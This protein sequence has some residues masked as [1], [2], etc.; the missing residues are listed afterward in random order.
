MT[1]NFFNGSRDRI[2]KCREHTLTW[3]GIDQMIS[4]LATYVR[5]DYFERILCISRG[6]LALGGLLGYAL[7]IRHI[8]VFCAVSYDER[9]QKEIQ[10]LD[11]PN[12]YQWDR[13]TTLIVDDIADT[14]RTM[15]VCKGIYS[16]AYRFALVAKPKGLDYINSFAMIVDQ[17]TWVNFPWEIKKGTRTVTHEEPASPQ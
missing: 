10:V 4:S 7:D 8:G 16:S 15:D 3:Q 14:G 6:G 9:S 12:P 17:D 2:I 13:E 1:T 11:A 5:P